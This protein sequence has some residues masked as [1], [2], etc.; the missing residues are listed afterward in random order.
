MKNLS[1]Y[2]LLA[3]GVAG[4]WGVKMKYFLIKIIYFDLYN[5]DFC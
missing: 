5:F 4:K 2:K 1:I 3:R